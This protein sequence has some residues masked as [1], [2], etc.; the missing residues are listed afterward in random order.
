MN[1]KG[2]KTNHAGGILAGITS[3][4]KSFSGLTANPY[5]Q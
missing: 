2:F 5:P 3:V 4:K 1:K